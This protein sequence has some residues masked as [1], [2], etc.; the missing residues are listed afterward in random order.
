MMGVLS[1]RIGPSFLLLRPPMNWGQA[2][3]SSKEKATSAGSLRAAEAA[4]RCCPSARLGCM[5]LVFARWRADIRLIARAGGN[6]IKL[7][8]SERRF[9]VGEGFVP[10]K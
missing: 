2:A 7:S 6:V 10:A 5:A 9:I 3:E 4:R 1:A 8:K